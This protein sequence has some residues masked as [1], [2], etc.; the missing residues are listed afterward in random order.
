MWNV[1][2]GLGQEYFCVAGRDVR[3]RF[4]NFGSVSVRFLK[5]TRI[6]F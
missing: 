6:R 4:F 5:K 3:N 1:G 2:M